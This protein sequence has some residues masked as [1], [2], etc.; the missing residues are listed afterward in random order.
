MVA[1]DLKP[2]AAG[3]S[4][5]SVIAVCMWQ[6]HAALVLAC[7]TAYRS[8]LHDSLKESPDS[9]WGDAQNAKDE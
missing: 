7:C 5:V 2:A 3:C 9:N 1:E 8:C 4:S 6:P